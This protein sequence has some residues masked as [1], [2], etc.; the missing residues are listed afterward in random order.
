M[1]GVVARKTAAHQ[2]SVTTVGIK[3]LAKVPLRAT[4]E[5]LNDRLVRQSV[6]GIF[7]P[8]KAEH[9]FADSIV[10]SDAIYKASPVM[11]V[12]IA[13]GVFHLRLGRVRQHGPGW[14]LAAVE[15]RVAH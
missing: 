4:L 7:V 5:M 11:S 8:G 10:V 13:S 2:R 1:L 3:V 9:G 12:M 14:K 6:K 15:V